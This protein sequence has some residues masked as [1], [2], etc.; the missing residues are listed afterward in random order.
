MAPHWSIF[1]RRVKFY[2]GMFY[3]I[4]PM[5]PPQKN[6][7]KREQSLNFKRTFLGIGRDHFWNKARD[8]SSLK[9]SLKLEPV[10]RIASCTQSYA[11]L[12]KNLCPYDANYAQSLKN[13]SKLEFKPFWWLKEVSLIIITRL[14]KHSSSSVKRLFSRFTL[15]HFFLY[16]KVFDLADL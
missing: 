6:R 2:S 5:A 10:R 14:I 12:R 16:T 15:E 4:G 9:M 7:R 3:R 11:E 13:C 1:Q 8:W